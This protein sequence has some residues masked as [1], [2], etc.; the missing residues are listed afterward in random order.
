MRYVLILFL[1]SACSNNKVEY[2]HGYIFNTQN[3]PLEGL[4]ISTVENGET[5]KTNK[6]GYFRIKKLENFSRYIVVSDASKN[7]LDTI[8]TS[9]RHPDVGG[10]NLQFVNGRMDTLFLQSK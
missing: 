6:E 4:V 3:E 2:Y 10:I 5:T 7:I 1:F 8:R 9:W